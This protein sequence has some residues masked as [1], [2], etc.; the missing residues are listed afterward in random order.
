MNKTITVVRCKYFNTQHSLTIPQHRRSKRSANLLNQHSKAKNPRSESHPNNPLLH[1]PANLRT[2]QRHILFVSF[3]ELQW[4]NWIYAPSGYGAYYCAGTCNFPFSHDVS[5]TN[6]AIVQTLA[7]LLQSHD[8][9][10]PCCA[11][12]KLQSISLLYSQSNDQFHIKRYR[13][14][15]AKTCVCQ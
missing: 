3:Q 12:A 6:H 9:P 10:K 14:M 1:K 13:D 2:C 11:P 15:I 5:A 7:H 4:D 8:I